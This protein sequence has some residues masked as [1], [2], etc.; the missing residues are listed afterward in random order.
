VSISPIF[1]KQLFVKKFFSAA[2]YV[3]TIWVCNFFW[4][5]DFGAKAAHKKLATLT[6]GVN[7]T[8]ILRAAFAPKAFCHKITNPNCKLIKAMTFNFTNI[9]RAAFSYQSSLHSF[10]CAYNL[11]L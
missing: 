4:Q 6:P 1:Y 2:F 3:L 10:L 8:N 5:K 7:F 11:G 9:L